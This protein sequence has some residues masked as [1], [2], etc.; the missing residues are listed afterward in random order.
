MKAAKYNVSKKGWLHNCVASYLTVLYGLVMRQ[1][2]HYRK[3]QSYTEERKR[4]KIKRRRKIAAAATWRWERRL[5]RVKTR[6]EE[7]N[8]SDI[9]KSRQSCHCRPFGATWNPTRYVAE[10]SRGWLWNLKTTR[11]WKYC[12]LIIVSVPYLSELQYGMK[13][14]FLKPHPEIQ[15]LILSFKWFDRLPYLKPR[16][17]ELFYIGLLWFPQWGLHSHRP[18]F[19]YFSSSICHGSQ[20][21][22]LDCSGKTN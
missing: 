20:R 4:K 1:K 12:N 13:M 17:L 22:E 16:N 7:S 19:L 15:D 3:V 8:T 6:R 21:G 14:W 10:D 9:E 18:S 2:F 5:G 11:F